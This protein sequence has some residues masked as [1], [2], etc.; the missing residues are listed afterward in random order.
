MRRL[1]IIAWL[2]LLPV[3]AIAAAEIFELRHR[4]A[5]EILPAIRDLAPEGVAVSAQGFRIVARGDAGALTELAAVV[6]SLDTPVQ[7]LRVSVRQSRQSQRRSRSLRGTGVIDGDGASSRLRLRGSGDARVRTSEQA[8]IVQSGQS[9]WVDA[10]GEQLV[11][12][13]RLLGRDRRG[14]GLLGQRIQARRWHDGFFVTAERRGDRV[15]VRIEVLREGAL[16]DAEAERFSLITNLETG[17]G[18]WVRLAGLSEDSSAGDRS[19][20]RRSRDARARDRSLWLRVEAM[21]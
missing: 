7:N 19:V 14:Q 20:L 3:T 1:L 10:G 5:S 2:C 15:S 16:E 21:P 13:E 9:A 6:R 4:P 17:L 12:T 11:V 8:V 18:E